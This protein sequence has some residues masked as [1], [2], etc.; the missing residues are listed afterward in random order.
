MN[1]LFTG[2]CFHL[3]VWSVTGYH[4]QAYSYRQ[5]AVGILP[6]AISRD[7]SLSALS[8]TSSLRQSNKYCHMQ[9]DVHGNK[10]FV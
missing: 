8:A 1:R 9:S 10:Y 7:C 5:D 4:Q 3:V 2:L 6:V